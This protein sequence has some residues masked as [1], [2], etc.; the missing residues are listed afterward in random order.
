[1]GSIR[2]YLK[3]NAGTEAPSELVFFDTETHIPPPGE[4]PAAWEHRLRLWTAVGLRLEGGKVTRREAVQG[5]EAWGFW[6]WLATRQSAHRPVWAFA[7]NLGFDLTT[8]G[9]W[10]R[11]QAQEYTIGPVI[12]GPSPKT[13]KPRRP[14]VGRLCLEG[15]PTFCV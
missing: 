2:R 3:G 4:K 1:M 10:Q 9:F 15:R 14:W 12:R 6:Q 8:L 13:G 7:H 5:K 11:L